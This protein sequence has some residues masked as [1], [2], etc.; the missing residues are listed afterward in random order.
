MNII[1]QNKLFKF[2][3][4]YLL[5]FFGFLFIT[6]IIKLSIEYFDVDSLYPFYSFQSTPIKSNLFIGI[7]LIIEIFALSILT[8]ILEELTFRFW[9]FTYSN[10][11]LNK[12]KLFLF[13]L[14]IYKTLFS[15]LYFFDAN[16]ALHKVL[17]KY[18]FF[19]GYLST[20]WITLFVLYLI[21]FSS[22]LFYFIC[23][24]FS[25][26]LYKNIL[27]I[28][29]FIQN[30]YTKLFCFSIIFY[31]YS[32]LN[33]NIYNL[34]TITLPEIVNFVTRIF[35]AFIFANTMKSYGLKIAVSLNIFYN[36]LQ[37]F[38][39]TIFWSNKSAWNYRIGLGIIVITMFVII[40]QNIR[41]KNDELLV[42]VNI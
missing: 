15:F 42:K 21:P 32:N 1:T 10:Q 40:I 16:S 9:L 11:I 14:F 37:Y 20:T 7:T 23:L 31:A 5:I 34:Q 8:P 27:Y 24:N 22:A 30:N 36:L 41:I 13:A 17:N 35:L 29:N 25:N 12:I 2:N 6:S 26:N 19:N 28:E 39:M 33:I 18:Y 3:T 4:K 38:L